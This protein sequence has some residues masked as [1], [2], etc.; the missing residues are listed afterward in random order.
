MKI[1][2]TPPENP[3]KEIIKKNVNAKQ[4]TNLTFLTVSLLVG[5]T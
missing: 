3:N 1:E 2:Y 5:T 4:Y